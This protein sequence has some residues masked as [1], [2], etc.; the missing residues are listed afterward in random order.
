MKFSI[1]LKL[2]IMMFCQ[3]L[4]WGGGYFG[5]YLYSTG[6]AEL[7][8][9]RIFGALP[10]SAIVAPFAIGIIADRF[11]SPQKVLCVQRDIAG[12]RIITLCFRA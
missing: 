6:Y 7:H 11:F 12:S 10:L 3:A 2:S 4:I 8:I 9:S 5:A 1:R